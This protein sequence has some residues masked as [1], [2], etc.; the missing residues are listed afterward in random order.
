[1]RN[2]ALGA[3]DILECAGCGVHVIGP[4]PHT[5]R[6]RPLLHWLRSEGIDGAIDLGHPWV[7][8]LAR[9]MA[10]AEF[11]LVCVDNL[12][13][14]V[15]A[16]V[17]IVDPADEARLALEHLRGLGH[18]HCGYLIV[19]DNCLAPERFA[20]FE[21]ESRRMG[22]WDPSL[23]LDLRSE[24]VGE[25]VFSLDLTTSSAVKKF[26]PRHAHPLAMLTHND[27]VAA[28]L[29]KWILDHR[30]TVPDDV[31]VIGVDNDPLYALGE[32]SLTT[33]ERSPGQMGREAAMLLLARL[34]GDRSS[35]R[36]VVLRPTL[37]VRSST[38]R[39]A[40][41]PR[42][43]R[44]VLTVMDRDFHEAKLVAKLAAQLG[45]PEWKLSRQ[46]HQVVGCTL[47]EYRNRQR[48][49][50]AARLLREQPYAKIGWVARRVGF[51]TRSRFTALFRERFGLAPASYQ[52]K[53]LPLR[54]H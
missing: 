40:D 24:C 14:A 48:L 54:E 9:P 21:Q 32:V 44:A 33:L 3:R 30:Y 6:R 7:D 20:A 13:T 23:V 51:S 49:D 28:A 43:L 45:W 47:L 16:D 38:V 29:L 19:T 35:H 17:V 15:E 4:D 22:M 12:A 11:P 31:A 34:R 42:W 1:M 39:L 37:I 53:R 18:S 5:G 27:F 10:T 2:A 50:L 46:F 26:F 52:R 41:A 25:D 36:R 8:C